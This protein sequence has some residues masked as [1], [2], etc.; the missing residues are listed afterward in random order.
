M[1]LVVREGDSPSQEDLQDTTGKSVS[2]NEEKGSIF[3]F[4]CAHKAMPRKKEGDILI[5]VGNCQLQDA[6]DLV[7]PIENS[8][9]MIADYLEHADLPGDEPGAGTLD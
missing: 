8:A 1:I 5:V 4:D 3:L 7:I 6:A 9:E 2:L